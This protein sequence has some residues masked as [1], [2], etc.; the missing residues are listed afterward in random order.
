MMEKLKVSSIIKN[1]IEIDITNI[2]YKKIVV[3]TG[4]R[5][6]KVKQI[7][8]EKGAILSNTVSKNTFLLIT[9][10]KDDTTVKIKDAIKLKIPIVTPDE[11]IKKYGD[12][13]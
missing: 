8:E 12:D 6:E 1:K 9:K 11:F 13:I 5:D 3:M 4:T 10:S 2:L 7:L